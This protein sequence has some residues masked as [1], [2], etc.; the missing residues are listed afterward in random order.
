MTSSDRGRLATGVEHLGGELADRL[1]HRE[2]GLAGLVVDADEALVDELPDPVD[3]VA[4]HLGG[5]AAYGLG[6]LELEAAA[7]D[8][9]PV[10]EPAGPVVEQVVAPGDRPAQRLLALRQ[11]A[12]AGGQAYRD[13]APGGPGS[14]P[15]S[16]A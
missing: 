3:D 15:G 9:Q 12:R 11:V 10:D 5:G 16:G 13:G 1:E 14:G 7:K 8:G 6:G 4:A 2:A